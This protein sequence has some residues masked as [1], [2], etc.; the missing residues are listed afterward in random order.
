MVLEQTVHVAAALCFYLATH[1]CLRAFI[2]DSQTLNRDELK[3][4]GFTLCSIRKTE[5]LYC[6][7]K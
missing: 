2:A 1:V 4:M 6:L 5:T 7:R 3:Q